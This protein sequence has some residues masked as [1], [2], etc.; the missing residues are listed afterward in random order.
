MRRKNLST[1]D[2]C[3]ESGSR[4]RTG[5]KSLPGAAREIEKALEC[6]PISHLIVSGKLMYLSRVLDPAA[7]EYRVRYAIANILRDRVANEGA[8]INCF[9]ME[10]G[11]EVICAILRRG[12]NNPILRRALERSH[13][14]NLTH[15]LVL[16]PEFSEAYHRIEQPSAHPRRPVKGVGSRKP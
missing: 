14:V 12:L 6:A 9:E 15:W 1:A 7:S 16:H 11:D 3:R 13:I 5:K 8:F 2:A 10:D 4:R